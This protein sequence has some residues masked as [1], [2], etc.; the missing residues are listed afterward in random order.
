[1]CYRCGNSSRTAV[2]AAQRLEIP[3][4]SPR[5]VKQRSIGGLSDNSDDDDED[6]CK[7]VSPMLSPAIERSRHASYTCLDNRLSPYVNDTR[8]LS[9]S[10]GA[11]DISRSPQQTQ[12]S[13]SGEMQH[14]TPSPRPRL[15]PREPGRCAQSLE[16]A[17]RSTGE[18]RYIHQNKIRSCDNDP[19]IQTNDYGRLRPTDFINSGMTTSEFA[20]RITITQNMRHNDIENYDNKK[21]FK[22]VV[23]EIQSGRRDN[24]N[25]AA[26][27]LST[28][29]VSET[30]N[31]AKRETYDMSCTTYTSNHSPYNPSNR[32]SGDHS[33]YNPSN[34]SSGDHS[35]YNSNNRSSGDSSHVSY[36]DLWKLRSTL[37]KDEPS[38]SLDTESEKVANT[39]LTVSFDTSVEPPSTEHNDSPLPRQQSSSSNSGPSNTND[40]CNKPTSVLHSVASRDSRRQ[41][42][43]AMLSHRYQMGGQRRQISGD[44]SF[45]SGGTDGDISDISKP[46]AATSFDESAT[47]STGDSRLI[48]QRYDSGYKSLETQMSQRDSLHAPDIAIKQLSLDSIDEC[49]L[50]RQISTSSREDLR[51]QFVD[52]NVVDPVEYSR[53]RDRWPLSHGA[54]LVTR[55]IAAAALCTC[56]NEANSR[57]KVSPEHVELQPIRIGLSGNT[58]S[59][60]TTVADEGRR[61]PSRNRGDERRRG[62]RSDSIYSHNV[63]RKSPEPLKRRA[64]SRDYS[65]DQKTDAIFNEFLRF[66]PQLETKNTHSAINARQRVAHCH[67]NASTFD[68]GGVSRLERLQPGIRSASLGSSE[69]AVGGASAVSK[70]I[71]NRRREATDADLIE[72]DARMMT[73]EHDSNSLKPGTLTKI[74]SAENVRIIRNHRQG[75]QT[76]HMSLFN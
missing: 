62:S 52:C 56:D 42:Y 72:E 74:P 20:D 12:R 64:M 34:R 37:E 45:E 55:R 7:E 14:S 50:M 13:H 63:P 15:L 29:T 9:S 53:P 39:P 60:T 58:T 32:S 49:Q 57:R 70:W 36:G 69:C 18:R 67:Y 6:R 27:R 2:K 19:Y 71:A 65:I 48:Q 5:I 8:R 33:P 40:S 41:T 76:R 4:K 38:D 51:P 59:S 61:S 35:P 28:T 3:Q 22:L 46:D 10:A 21:L 43:K 16:S 73:A 24:E 54:D 66:D 1:M 11:A 44:T 25:N 30:A 75:F 68:S 26:I 47:D 23:S 17:T 31:N